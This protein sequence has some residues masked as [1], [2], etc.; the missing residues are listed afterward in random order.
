MNTSDKR[1]LPRRL[2]VEWLVG[3]LMIAGVVALVRAFL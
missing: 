2:Y 1:R 3:A